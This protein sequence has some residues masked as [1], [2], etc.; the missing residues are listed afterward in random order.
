MKKLFII[1]LLIGSNAYNGFS[2][3]LQKFST[4]EIKNDLV[5]LRHTLEAS[6]YDFYV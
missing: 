3:P 4:E 1:F 6:H 2:Q 5:Y